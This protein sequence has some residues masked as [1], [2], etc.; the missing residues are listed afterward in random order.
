[1]MPSVETLCTLALSEVVVDFE[2]CIGA[3][4]CQQ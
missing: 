1:M 3:P 4:I 2:K